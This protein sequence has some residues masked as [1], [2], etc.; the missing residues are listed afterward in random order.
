[1]GIRF[2]RQYLK[3]GILESVQIAKFTYKFIFTS[4]SSTNL[5]T[6]A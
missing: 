1:M 4:L 3:L 5:F 6:M 2:S